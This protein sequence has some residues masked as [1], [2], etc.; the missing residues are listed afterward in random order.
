MLVNSWCFRCARRLSS[1]HPRI[2]LLGM[3]QALPNHWP[4]SASLLQP[5]PPLPIFRYFPGLGGPTAPPGPLAIL[6]S[7]PCPNARRLSD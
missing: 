7:S 1:L 4:R 2:S 3:L 6:G 5:R